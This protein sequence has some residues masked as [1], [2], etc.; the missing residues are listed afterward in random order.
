MRQPKI[1]VVTIVYN[2]IAHIKETMD[3]VINQNYSHIEYILIDGASTDGTR[4][5]IESTLREIA[6][7]SSLLMCEYPPEASIATIDNFSKEELEN[8]ATLDSAILGKEAPFSIK[9]DTPSFYLQG[10]RKDNPYFTFKF[11]SQKDSGIYDAMNKG[12]DLASGQ[13]CNF[14]NCGDRFYANT[15]IRE[16]FEAFFLEYGGGDRIGVIYGDACIMYS[17]IESK[18]LYSKTTNHKYHHHFIHQS[19]FI[20]TALIKYT[21]YNQSFKIAGDTDFFTKAYNAGAKFLHFDV[22]I[23]RFNVE[24]VSSSLSWQMF[25]EDC[26]IGY[27]YNKFYPIWYGLRYTFYIVPRVCVRNAIPQKWRNKARVTFGKKHT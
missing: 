21:K 22:V 19:A 13:W 11:L 15:S 2:D 14:M 10:T 23:A 9:Y 1:S 18:I 3:S 17:H 24:G 12:I 8:L 26:Q 7:D 5:C 20:D 4:E 25:K 27:K 6:L 16:L